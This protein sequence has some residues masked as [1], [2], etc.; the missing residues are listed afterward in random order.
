MDK[1]K[2]LISKKLPSDIYFQFNNGK[3]ETERGGGRGR[4]WSFQ[5]Y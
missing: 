1:Q 5:E 4:I 3:N 2:F